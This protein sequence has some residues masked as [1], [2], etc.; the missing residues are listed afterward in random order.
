MQA[1]LA[2]LGR[3]RAGCLFAPASSVVHACAAGTIGTTARVFATI[4]QIVIA[5]CKAPL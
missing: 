2:H 1:T 4:R 3:A 5:S